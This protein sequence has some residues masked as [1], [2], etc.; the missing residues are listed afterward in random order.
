MLLSSLLKKLAQTVYF[1]FFLFPLVALL[2]LVGL[3]AMESVFWLSL[4]LDPMALALLTMVGLLVLV[5][6]LVM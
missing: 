2:V 6:L 1:F 5:M 4:V 3:L